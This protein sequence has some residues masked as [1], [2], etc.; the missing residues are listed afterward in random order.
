MALGLEEQYLIFGV[1]K[2]AFDLWRQGDV[3]G[4]KAWFRSQISDRTGA[5]VD[6]GIATRYTNDIGRFC[7]SGADDLWLTLGPGYLYWGH[8]VPGY[9]IID[10]Y[11]EEN[12][13]PPDARE[14][15]LLARK[16][17]GGWKNSDRAGRLL[18]RHTLH[19]KAINW[20]TQQATMGTIKEDRYFIQLIMGQ[21]LTEWHTRQDMMDAAMAAGWQPGPDVPVAPDEW[22]REVA[23]MTD[24]VMNTAKHSN[25]Q[26]VERV[27]KN[28]EIRFTKAELELE[29]IRLL[30]EKDY[31]CAIT[32][33]KLIK[34][35]KWLQ[36]SVD[37][38]CSDGHY[39]PGNIQITSWA[40]NRTKGDL[41]DADVAALLQALQM[42]GEDDGIDVP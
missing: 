2:Q 26:I 24:S 4:T 15:Y 1:A 42:G 38:I 10:T 17:D 40:A 19:P 30:E 9:E 28:K 34:G 11:M 3:P 5:P 35:D 37:R 41:P 8:A 31:R 7:E 12:S 33:R 20:L 23:R 36:P 21:P 16:I 39:E 13:N 22:L 27:I 6:S 14:S 18:E 32:R 29:I 25:G